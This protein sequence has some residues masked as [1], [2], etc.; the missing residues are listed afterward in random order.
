M[1]E[2]INAQLKEAMKA[3]DELKMTTLRMML[4]A[5]SIAEKKEPGKPVDNIQ[6]FNS[7]IKQRN[8]TAVEYRSANQEALALREE[9]EVKIIE[10][11]LPKKMTDEEAEVALKAVIV[12][13]DAKDQK[14]LGKVI[15]GFNAKHNGLYDNKKLSEKIRSMLA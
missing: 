15:K 14:D 10:G 7:M 8:N 11:F 13:V 4:S 2:E 5:L 9:S 6:V 1:K 3:K 12:E